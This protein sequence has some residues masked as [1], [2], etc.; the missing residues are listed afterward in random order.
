MTPPSH[1]RLRHVLKRVAIPVLHGSGLLRLAGR[2]ESGQRRIALSYHNVDPRVFKKHALFLKEHADVVGIEEF[3]ASLSSNIRKPLITLTFDDGYA[4]F[5]QE[6]LPTLQAHR[7]PATWF[8]PTA[9]VGSSDIFWF[10]RLRAAILY[11]PKTQLVCDGQRWSLR[12]W[13]RGYVVASVSKMLKQTDAA[14]GEPLLADFLKQLGEPPASR[15]QRFQLASREHLRGLDWDLVT[16]GSH[17]HTHAQLTQLSDEELAAELQTSKQL[18][19]QWTRR[20][21]HHFAFP[22]GNYDERVIQGIRMAG[23]RSAWTTELRMVSSGD[24]PYRLPR[25]MIDD[26]APVSILVAKMTPLIHRMGVV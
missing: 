26:F 19:E 15:L 20:P 14:R 13:N 18:L 24:G 8:V 16:L 21:V 12:S 1:H 7:L 22:S 10:D 9:F 17:S 25:I 11:S 3:L 5:A 4:S 23:Y 6:I 2:L